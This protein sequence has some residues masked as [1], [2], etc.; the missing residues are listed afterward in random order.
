[1]RNKN[2]ERQLSSAAFPKGIII[3][4]LIVLS[5]LTSCSPAKE[6]NSEYELG[7]IETTGS[8]NT[9]Y[10][11]FCGFSGEKAVGIELDVGGILPWNSHK[12]FNNHIYLGANGLD[13][14]KDSGIVLEINKDNGE[15]VKHKIWDKPITA[16]AVSE[17]NIFVAGNLNNVFQI[18]SYDKKTQAVSELEL[19]DSLVLYMETY[20]DRIYAFASVLG[21]GQNTGLIYVI[22]ISTMKVLAEIDIS[23]CGSLQLDSCMAGDILYF[24]CNR[25]IEDG[26][27]TFIYGF[28]T[29]NHEILAYDIGSPFPFQIEIDDDRLFISHYDPV[30]LAGNGMTVLDPETE[31]YSY[32]TLIDI[33]SQFEI[34]EDKLLTACFPG[35]GRTESA[36]HVYS[37]DSLEPVDT[38]PIALNH[39]SHY[40][41]SFFVK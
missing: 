14:Q 24:T 30:N 38:F 1:M 16:I 23:S 21:R 17:N 6:L 29:V 34:Y 2:R 37:L 5:L 25:S 41:V 7:F 11:T 4:L 39:D 26:L 28:N 31:T 13:T 18:A 19:A 8:E 12:T 32:H 27:S 33:I 35:S 22:E 15:V 3:P 10:I 20:G 40:L 36:F 9:G